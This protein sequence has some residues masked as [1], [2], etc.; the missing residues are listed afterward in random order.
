MSGDRARSGWSGKGTLALLL[1]AVVAGVGWLVWRPAA[2]R[3]DL[4][5][6]MAVASQEPGYIEG[7]FLEMGPF[8]I[9]GNYQRDRVPP[10]PGQGVDRLQSAAQVVVD[11]FREHLFALRRAIHRGDV[12]GERSMRA[13]I[14]RDLRE[15]GAVLEREGWRRTPAGR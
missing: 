2:D 6:S 4:L 15:Y 11:T 1:L 14:E 12:N 5:A 7:W 8:M 13:A 3:G 10:D 9:D